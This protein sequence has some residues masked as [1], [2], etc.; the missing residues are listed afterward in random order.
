MAKKKNSKEST[1][2]TPII[3][4]GALGVGGYFI[5]KYFKEKAPDPSNPDGFNISKLYYEQEGE[6]IDFPIVGKNFDIVIIA[7]NKSKTETVNG[8]CDIINLD[9]DETIFSETITIEP[10]TLKTFVH[11]MIMPEIQLN[12]AIKTGRIIDSE[13]VEDHS[14]PLEIIPGEQPIPPGIEA[15]I[16]S[17]EFI[18]V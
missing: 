16:I 13:K 15:E 7:I 9:T 10:I 6:M 1:D 3:M 2:I 8:Y 17:T 12:V 11:T 4:L 18:K 5:Y 14:W